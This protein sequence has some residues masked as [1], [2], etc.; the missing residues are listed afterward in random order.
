M[1]KTSLKIFVV[2]VFV[3][4]AKAVVPI[5]VF[6]QQAP[7]LELRQAVADNHDLIKVDL[8]LK[9]N[10][11]AISGVS[12]AVV[13]DVEKLELVKSEMGEAFSTVLTEPSDQG[14]EVRVA[15]GIA[16]GEGGVGKESRI[17]SLWFRPLGAKEELETQL[18]LTDTMITS[19]DR[20]D[21]LAE[22][23]QT[24]LVV[25]GQQVEMEG[26]GNWLLN[27]IKKFLAKLKQLVKSE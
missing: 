17:A 5:K 4:L 22:G 9:P 21:N 16:P 13:Y 15:V 20:E 10:R 7:V 12:T 27:L 18:S 19:L 6:A 26:G 1:Y 23:Q 11:Q 8:W 25:N 24:T 3:W 2:F 14:G